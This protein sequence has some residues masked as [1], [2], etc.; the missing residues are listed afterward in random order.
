MVNDEYDQQAPEAGI[1]QDKPEVEASTKALVAEWLQKMKHAE[2]C[3]KDVFKQMRKNMELAA[4]GAEDQW[5]KGD[6]FTVPVLNRH[7]NQAVAQLYAKN[8]TALAKRKRKLMYTVWDEKPETLQQ[9][10]MGY[11]AAQM[12]AQQ[13]GVPVEMVMSQVDP[14][15]MVLLQEVQ[16]AQTHNLMLD[17]MGKTM[18]LL[19]DY[20]TAEQASGFKTQMKALVRRAKVCKVGYVKLCFQRMLEK[21]PEIGA[22]ID[23]ATSM[24]ASVEGLAKRAEKEEFDQDSARMGELTALMT[25]VS[26]R[27]EIIAR[28]GPVFDFPRSDEILIDP[29]CRHLRTFTGARWIAHY[30]DMTPEEVLETYDVD[31]KKEGYAKHEDEAFSLR[32]IDA[33]KKDAKDKRK[34]LCRVYE[35]QDRKNGQFFTIA[36]GYADFLKPPAE[37]DV[38]IERF[39]TVFPLVFNEI[40]H[41]TE[42]YPPSDVELAKH[43][44]DEYNRSRQGLR[45]HRQANRPFWVTPK[46]TLEQKDMDKLGAHA[47]HEVIELKGM[48]PGQPIDSMVQRGPVSPIDP[49]QY[50]V[51]AL[52]Q[53]MLRAVGTQDAQYGSTSGTTAT[54]SSIAEANRSVSIAD[55]VDDLD[56]MLTELA[57]A[58]G[59]LM[60]FEMSPDTVKEIAGPGAVWPEQRPSR[61]DIAKE[62][63]LEIK[64]GSS[65]RPN[66]A[67]DMAKWER[68]TPIL[69]QIPGMNP[70]VIAQRMCDLLEIDFKE[71]YVEGLPSIMSQNTIAGAGAQPMAG[72]DPASEPSAQ[73]AQGGNNAPQAQGAQPGGQP[74]F[75]GP[76]A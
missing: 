71:A 47:S 12:V 50:D 62:L 59:Q 28:E 36:A 41:A 76:Q 35:V 21:R 4:N 31:V 10:M 33:S 61:E 44:Q 23:D 20:F 57:R 8:P 55:N 26:Q 45:E 18:E 68:A 5:I 75:A 56:D 69:L 72:G 52:W 64:A 42:I 3:S 43:I 7:I 60:L 27:E 73:G 6:N 65:G 25:D 37:P 30:W 66:Q 13:M 46:G 58:T 2:S 1:V 38:M 16:Q 32:S 63:H 9:A 49:A 14:Q 17:R 39:F 29:A 48:K 11:Q 74:Q 54:E 34:D 15:A 67:A 53:D 40:E 24:L 70:S 19:W 22:Q 51:N